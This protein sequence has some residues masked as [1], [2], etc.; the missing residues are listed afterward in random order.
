M[1]ITQIYKRHE[2]GFGDCYILFCVSNKYNE[3][4]NASSDITTNIVEL[5]TIKKDLE[6]DSG[7]FV[8]DALNFSINELSCNT[9][10]DINSLFFCLNASNK[11]VKRYV[12]VFLLNSNDITERN[13]N[14]CLF[15][16]VINSKISGEDLVWNSHSWNSQ[17][18]IKRSY[19]FTANS[20]AA[21]ILNECKFTETIVK[22][23]VHIQNIYE[24]FEANNYNQFTTVNPTINGVTAMK[25]KLFHIA[26]KNDANAMV[27]PTFHYPTINL[28]DTL[29]LYLKECQD[30]LYSLY[31]INYTIVLNPFD[32]G[33]EASW[34]NYHNC[35]N[36]SIYCHL[37]SIQSV[38]QST[39]KHKLRCCKESDLQSDELAISIHRGLIS[40]TL[41]NRAY[42]MLTTAKNLMQRDPSTLTPEEDMYV[43][44]FLRLMELNTLSDELSFEKSCDNMLDLLNKIAFSFGLQLFIE[45]TAPTTITITFKNRKSFPDTTIY[46]YNVQGSGIDTSWANS[47]NKRRFYSQSTAFS[48]EPSYQHE[49][50]IA[51]YRV[52]IYPDA[53]LF[54]EDT[55]KVFS[56]QVPIIGGPSG[57][58]GEPEYSNFT[59]TTKLRIEEAQ[60]ERLKSNNKYDFEKIIMSLGPNPFVTLSL[61]AGNKEVPKKIYHKFTTILNTVNSKEF[62]TDELTVETKYNIYNLEYSKTNPDTWYFNNLVGCYPETL[63][64]NIFVNPKSTEIEDTYSNKTE[65]DTATPIKTDTATIMAVLNTLQSRI[66][67][68]ATVLYVKI[69]NVNKEYYNLADYINDIH[70]LDEDIYTTELNLEIPQWNCFSLNSN[71]S[72]PSLFNLKVGNILTIQNY[73]KV[74]NELTNTFD[75]TTT[76]INYIVTAVEMDLTSPKLKISLQ[77]SERFAFGYVDSTYNAHSAG[78]Y[79]NDDTDPID[80]LE[81]KN[82]E[83]ASYKCAGDIKK[84][85]AVFVYQSNNEYVIETAQSSYFD[86]K[87]VIGIA[88]EGGSTDDYIKIATGG[89][90]YTGGMMSIQAEDVGKEIFVRCYEDENMNLVIPEGN[91]RHIAKVFGE[92][93]VYYNLSYNDIIK[94][95][96][97]AYDGSPQK[98]NIVEDLYCKI[99]VVVDAYKIELNIQSS[100]I[101]PYHEARINPQH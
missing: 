85:D 88:L 4:Y 25:Y 90:I 98:R 22:N 21:T 27:Y 52:H 77:N 40:G 5:E 73:S 89:T 42:K 79:L 18:N 61:N 86:N 60:R 93:P 35:H 6:N 45:M 70:K 33:V 69:R 99:G 49:A 32:L 84:G 39:T 28:Y 97:A 26:I 14:N 3:L 53:I 47:T 57:P 31:N 66:T 78:N 17:K 54:L 38:F 41:M 64:T 34:A 50:N 7:N 83:T 15:S 68:P 76:D 96:T 92:P 91:L 63:L 19:K 94:T 75:E 37:R 20:L 46:L 81:N 9:N 10:D 13:V 56:S 44:I 8:A 36:T 30:I 43:K 23:N 58:L 101:I 2:H 74:F 59:K 82:I 1:L 24:R 29:R 87:T 100:L 51:D 67:R 11:D 71:G 95:D 55:N 62:N 72:N 80:N 16:G 65:K 48:S 12:A